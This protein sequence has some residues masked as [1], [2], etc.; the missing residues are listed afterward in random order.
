MGCLDG[1]ILDSERLQE[2]RVSWHGVCGE[3]SAGDHAGAQPGS[4]QTAAG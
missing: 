3:V 2:G 4:A 1:V